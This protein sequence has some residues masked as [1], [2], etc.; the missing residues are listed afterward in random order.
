MVRGAEPFV[1]VAARQVCAQIE[2]EAAH[3]NA[4]GRRVTVVIVLG[5]SPKHVCIFSQKTHTF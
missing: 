3:L 2:H 4:T 5:E 1:P